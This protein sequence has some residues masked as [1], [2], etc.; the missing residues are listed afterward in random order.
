MYTKNSW[1]SLAPL[2]LIVITGILLSLA[3]GFSAGISSTFPILAIIAVIGGLLLCFFRIEQIVLGLLIIRSGLDIFSAQQVPA[4]FAIFWDALAITYIGTLIARRRPIYTDYFFY[5]FTAWVLLQSLWVVLLPLGGLGMGAGHTPDALKE[6]IRIFS[7][8]MA[9]LLVL[10][11]KDRIKPETIVNALFFSMV[12]PLLGASMQILLPPSLLP[13]F[14]GTTRAHTAIEDA[15]RINGTLGHPNAFAT[16]LVLFLGLSYWRMR[17]AQNRWPWLLLMGVIAFFI[18]STKAL[19][20][21]VMMSI[22]VIGIVTPELTLPKF[23]GAVV[24]ISA[25]LLIFGSSEFGRERLSVFTE[26]P[27]FRDDIDVSRAI[28]LRRYVTNSFYWRLD[29]WTMLLE[30]WRFEPWFGYGLES[31]RHL[32]SLQSA[33]H[34]DYIRFLVEGGIVG[35]TSF[36]SFLFSAAFYLFK[37]YCSKIASP[38]Q[39]EL[40]LVLVAIL[41]AM[42]VGM[43]TENIWSHTALYFYWFTLISLLSWDW[44]TKAGAAPHLDLGTYTSKSFP[45]PNTRN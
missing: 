23:L 10:Q 15:S 20:G 26:I 14:L 32:T 7:W 3:I 30:A 41:A 39:S 33:A 8:L 17:Q 25:L 24:A 34:N 16:F 31:P 6:W 5:L 13:W 36:V 43:L 28:V 42:M 1:F 27:F 12:L 45:P 37:K 40:A 9:Y 19:V 2:I 22:L 35:L 11:L 21:L 44:D 29:Q 38:A 4:L 18:I